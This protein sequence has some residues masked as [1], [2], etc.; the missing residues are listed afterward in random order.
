LRTFAQI[1]GTGGYVPQRVITNAEM[2]EKVNTS[3]GWIVART[4]I[5][6]RH[7]AAEGEVT[8]DMAVMAARNALEMAHTHPE[9][10]DLIVVGTVTGDV[11]FPATAAFVQAKLGARRACAFD[12]SAAC[13]GSLFSLSVAEQYIRSGTAR[14]AL[15]IGADLLSRWIDW[16]DRATCVLFGDGAGAMVLAPSEESGRGVLSTHLHS[17]GSLAEILWIPAMGSRTP[18]TAEVLHQRLDKVKMKGHEVFRAAVRSLVAVA[19]EALAAN[20]IMAADVNHVFA[21]QANQRV[22]EAVMLRLEIP[23]ER[24]WINIDRFGNTSAASMPLLLDE[25]N[26][27]GRLK[28]GDLALMLAFGAGASWGSALVRW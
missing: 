17:D 27:A 26:R 23:T 20:G 22:L 3:D 11:P 25:A 7:V 1:V 16:Q 24:C 6:E 13:A 2:T 8:S 19:R 15:V 10:L 28:K 18:A 21:H 14:R 4:G 9:E 5:K 12:I